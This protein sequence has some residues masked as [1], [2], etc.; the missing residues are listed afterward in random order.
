MEGSAQRE[1]MWSML[2]IK[3]ANESGD[4]RLR[5]AEVACVTAPGFPVSL[6]LQVAIPLSLPHNFIDKYVSRYREV[7]RLQDHDSTFETI[8]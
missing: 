6:F 3:N 7:L 5:Q 1:G 4:L 8:S 2:Q